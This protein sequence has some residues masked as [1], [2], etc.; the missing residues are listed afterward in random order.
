MNPNP[1][2]LI[3]FEKQILKARE[4]LVNLS[5]SYANSD[6]KL[7][8]DKINFM[9]SELKY[10]QNQYTILAAKA[11]ANTQNAPVATNTQNAPAS[12]KPVVAPQVPP[13]QPDVKPAAAVV[14]DRSAERSAEIAKDVSSNLNTVINNPIQN[15]AKA[16]AMPA[17]EPVKPH[18]PNIKVEDVN[19]TIEDLNAMGHDNAFKTE[20]APVKEIAKPVSAAPERK[21]YVPKAQPKKSI[22]NRVGGI[23]MPILAAGLIF[24]SIILLSIAFIPVLGDIF[25]QVA[26]FGAGAIL[27]GSGLLVYK[28]TDSKV[29]PP[30]LLSIG[31]GEVYVSLFVCNIVFKSIN[32][33]ALF[34]LILAWSAS[35]VALRKFGSSLFN[36]IGNLGV[37]IAVGMGIYQVVP[38]SDGSKLLFILIF[39]A[40]SKLSFY[41]FFKDRED[42]SDN[43]IFHVFN[44]F[45]LCALLPATL[46]ISGD[47]FEAIR[48]IL[49]FV[50]IALSMV[51]FMFVFPYSD[52]NKIVFSV[53]TLVYTPLYVIVVLSTL[54]FY[55]VPDTYRLIA[56]FAALVPFILI[57]EFK[58]TQTVGSYIVEASL[59]LTQIV[60]LLFDPDSF[61][62][63]YI[64]LLL[65]PLLV[66]GFVRK[67]H[68]FK[69]SFLMAFIIYAFMPGN[70]PLRIG[71][72]VVFALAFYICLYRFDEQ[73]GT[74]YKL[75]T[76]AATLLYAITVSVT[77]G[78]N[79][80]IEYI[81]P[82]LIVSAVA[83]LNL[84]LMY[85]PLNHNRDEYRDVFY[86]PDV[87][88]YI[89]SAVTLLMFVFIDDNIRIFFI[90]WAFILCILGLFRGYLRDITFHKIAP[91]L[92]TIILALPM[93]NAGN[94]PYVFEAKIIFTSVILILSLIL[95]YSKKERYLVYYKILSI[96]AFAITLPLIMLDCKQAFELPA[97]MIPTIT[98]SVLGIINLLT[99]F[100]P[101]AKDTDGTEDMKIFN[102]IFS[103]V[104]MI[105]STAATH[106]EG[107]ETAALVWIFA[108]MLATVLK[109][110]ILDSLFIRITMLVFT[111]FMLFADAPVGAVALF[112]VAFIATQLVSM[113]VK[114]ESYSLICKAFLYGYGV[115]YAIVCT[116]TNSE[117]LVDNMYLT[118]GNIIIAV[119]AM[120][121]LIYTFTP[122]IKDPQTDLKDM[123]IFSLVSSH[124]IVLAALCITFVQDNPAAFISGIVTVVLLPIGLKRFWTERET[125]DVAFVLS[126]IECTLVPFLLCYAWSTSGI[127]ADVV[128]IIISTAYI[129]LGFKFTYKLPR[130]YGL[131]VIII[132]IFKM[133]MLDYGHSSTVG[134]AVGFL[135]SGVICLAISLIYN[136][137]DRKMVE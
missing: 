126:I 43:V 4:Q 14:F 112:A 3:E 49:L 127:V 94:S 29:I 52:K 119:I 82:A 44:Y 83:L 74:V 22:E 70:L 59:V 17:A 88:N 35:L 116:L 11:T 106:V 5:E 15:E 63:G 90:A 8:L 78:K 108:I 9:R 102:G 51:D 80:D 27:I 81:T 46:S 62:Y 10:L 121:S 57:A 30:L 72:G 117:S 54:S 85:S 100:T 1:N 47:S 98:L 58:F 118:P 101:L 130:I 18:N 68:A 122:L 128:A 55:G 48:L 87:M 26:F 91:V 75:L 109:S 31:M 37:A 40:I 131:V 99:L 24:I 134:Y 64:V 132:M 41:I 25:K 12:V 103:S 36:I 124:V 20:Q 34:I 66:L 67:N 92:M 93:E 73:Y 42:I 77:Y 38:V 111:A 19:L 105:Y 129:I 125:Y 16:K 133:T 86:I 56:A 60:L 137:I 65:I 53:G 120:Q 23:I 69:Y 115:L 71:V 135:I 6:D 33:I 136:V 45:E 79:S 13:V 32:D 39:F 96:T 21:P 123:E 110:F 107:S 113:Y 95:V 7:A 61:K 114:T 84:L 28:K 76:Y 89:V 104:L 2:E 50:C 97:G